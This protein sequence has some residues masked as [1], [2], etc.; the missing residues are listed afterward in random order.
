MINVAINGFGRVERM[1]LRAG[2]NDKKIN[3]VAIN[4]L[5]DTETL[6]YLLKYDS[7]QGKFNQ[8]IGFTKNSITIGNKNIPVTAEKEPNKLPWKKQKIDVVVES[9]GRF[10]DP[11]KAALH[12][13]AGAKK[14][15]LSA[16]CKCEDN[17]CPTNTETIVMGVNEKDYNKN[18]HHIISNASC[19]TN[20]VAPLLKVINDNY[21][22][23]NCF[24]STIHAYTSSM[25]LVDAPAKKLRRTRAAAVNIIPTNTGADVAT[26]EA[27]PELKGKIKGMAFRVP[28]LD[29]SITDFSIETKKPVTKETVNLLLKKSAKTK[30]KGIM[31]Y[32][33]EELV[34]V[35][36]IGNSHSTIVDSDLTKVIGKNNLKLLSWYD[37]EWGYSC[38]MIDMVKY[39]S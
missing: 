14:V 8:K 7:A 37:N 1:V 13:Q 9:T 18:K 4:D 21:G 2:W 15:L 19:T 12:L 28:I 29:G 3:F 30:L 27:I 38:R 25:H 35:D 10:V 16:P 33:E 32:S 34:S 11:V 24:F 6:A 36:I 26:V 39:I 31:E 5:T 17:V 23:K 20:C 22:I